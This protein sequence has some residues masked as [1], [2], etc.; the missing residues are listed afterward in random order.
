M[1]STSGGHRTWLVSRDEVLPGRCEWALKQIVVYLDSKASG[2]PPVRP[3]NIPTQIASVCL[4]N[5]PCENSWFVNDDNTKPTYHYCKFSA[6]ARALGNPCA[7][8]DEKFRG[9]DKGKQ[10]QILLP[11]Q[12]SIRFKIIDLEQ[13]TP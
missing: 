8:F 2:L 10:G 6:T 9:T 7:Y 13:T 11:N 12:R 1:T 3:S 5:E 4:A